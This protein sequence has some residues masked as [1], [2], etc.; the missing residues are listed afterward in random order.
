MKYYPSL[1]SY[2]L[3]GRGTQRN[4]RLLLKFLAALGIMITIYTVAFPFLMAGE[5]KEHSWLTGFY[6]TLV[7]MSTLG[8]GD[9]TFEG[10]AGRAFSILVLLSGVVFLLI[11]FPFTFIKFWVF[12]QSSGCLR[13]ILSFPGLPLPEES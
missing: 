6:W 3:S 9:I 7:V 10:D 4:L 12:S 1:L 8:F 11:L 5:G 2:F 13:K